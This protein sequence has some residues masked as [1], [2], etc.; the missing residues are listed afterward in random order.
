MITKQIRGKILVKYHM[1]RKEKE[2]KDRSEIIH[3]LK[4]Q[5]FT[6]ISM[7]HENEPYLVTLSYGYDETKNAFYFH[8][9]KEGQK[10]DFIKTNPFVCGTVIED[11][12]YAPGCGQAFR[13]VVYRG[14]II[15]IEDLQEKIYGFDIL[16]NQLEVEPATIKEKFLKKKET[17]ENS[18]MLRLDIDDL[19]CKE[20][21][22]GS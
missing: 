16:L 17:Y 10:I 6:T 19:T 4:Q 8:C 3:I 15:I 21:K 18:G 9:A 2:I 20:E 7:C 13:S 5:K 1:K 11:N 22:A 12:G 14:K